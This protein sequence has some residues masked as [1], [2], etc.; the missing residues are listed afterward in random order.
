MGENGSKG[1]GT[2]VSAFGLVH[3]GFATS[4]EFS[5]TLTVASQKS[6]V[7]KGKQNGIA[8]R[9]KTKYF[10]GSLVPSPREVK[11]SYDWTASGFLV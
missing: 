2:G 9:T 11:L 5:G 6:P 4:L 10:W 7:P 8:S 1:R 3:P